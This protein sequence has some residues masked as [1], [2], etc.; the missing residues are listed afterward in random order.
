MILI[1]E[2]IEI[3]NYL[4]ILFRIPLFYLIPEKQIKAR[5]WG[6]R[7]FKRRI[8]NTTDMTNAELIIMFMLFTK[9]KYPLIIGTI[10]FFKE[11]KNYLNAHF[12]NRIEVHYGNCEGSNKFEFTNIGE[13]HEIDSIFVVGRFGLN[14][15][16]KQILVN[17]GLDDKEYTISRQ[18]EL[19]TTRQA[20]GT[21]K[22]LNRISIP[23][24][25]F[26][27][28]AVIKKVNLKISVATLQRVACLERN[29]ITKILKM[30][31]AEIMNFFGMKTKKQG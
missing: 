6:K 17:M 16:D 29:Q 12:P 23:I 31:Q 22:F 26:C 13:I 11:H 20:V 15:L 21:R 27:D 9:K 14:P 8:N 1:T 7:K 30:N 19:N 28:K 4:M 25:F 2:Y 24:F 10:Q 3:P 18:S 5:D